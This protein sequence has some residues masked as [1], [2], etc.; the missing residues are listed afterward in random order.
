MEKRRRGLS[1]NLQHGVVV[2]L[3]LRDFVEEREAGGLSACGRGVEIGVGGAEHVENAGRIAIE[4]AR[5]LERE[6]REEREELA[7]VFL[8]VEARLGERERRDGAEGGVEGVREGRSEHVGEKGHGFEERRGRGVQLEVR[9]ENVHLG[10]KGE[11]W[12]RWVGCG[13]RRGRS[14]I[15]GRRNRGRRRRREATA[16]LRR[17]ERTDGSPR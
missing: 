6:G 12:K 14:R 9:E 13:E 1:E 16:A 2:G 11:T 8:F 15:R 5:K 4:L 3:E 7:D 10:R 17:R